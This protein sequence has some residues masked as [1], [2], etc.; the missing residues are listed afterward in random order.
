MA[1]RQPDFLA[2][3]ARSDQGEFVGGRRPMAG[4][5]SRGLKWGQGR[6]VLERA[7]E[8]AIQNWLVNGGIRRVELPGGTDQQL[9]RPARLKVERHRILVERMG[10]FEVPQFDEN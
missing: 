6:H 7:V 1:S 10:T 9:D 3:D 4:P 2:T 5:N 8:H